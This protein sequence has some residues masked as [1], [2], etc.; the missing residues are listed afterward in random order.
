MCILVDPLLIRP[1]ITSSPIRG[2]R[3]PRNSCDPILRNGWGVS[4]PWSR[5]SAWRRGVGG[6]CTRNQLIGS[7]LGDGL[8]VNGCA[9]IEH[10][11]H[12]LRSFSGESR[13]RQTSLTSSADSYSSESSIS[14]NETTSFHPSPRSDC[15]AGWSMAKSVSASWMA[16]L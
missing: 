12:L 6:T 2:V 15:S 3:S 10:G 13:H 11:V 4:I 1:S 7:F 14:S 16:R 5:A 8:A 9:E